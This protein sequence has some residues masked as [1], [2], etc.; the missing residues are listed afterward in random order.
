M[1]AL[2]EKLAEID[3]GAASP[4]PPESGVYAIVNRATRRVYIGKSSNLKIRAQTHAN[5]LRKG[6]H[7]NRSLQQDW[8]EHGPEAFIFAPLK[9]TSD[10]AEMSA[11]ENGYTA[12]VLALGRAY[13]TVII[14]PASSTPSGG[15]PPIE[16]RR[17]SRISVRTI[18]RIAEKVYRNGTEWLEQLILK[19]KD[20]AP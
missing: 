1:S 4:M 14:N 3:S 2:Q 10:P 16:R 5:Q 7:C 17:S 8:R 11:I 13:N 18:P 12:E 15:R 20:K 6:I 9:F 19:A